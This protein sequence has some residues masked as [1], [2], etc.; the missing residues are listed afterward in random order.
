MKFVTENSAIAGTSCVSS[1]TSLRLSMPKCEKNT[2]LMNKVNAVMENIGFEPL[3]EKVTFGGSDAADLTAFGVPVLDQLGV[4]C[5][6][7][8]TINERIDLNSLPYCAKR[9]AAIAAL[10]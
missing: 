3:K 6:G 10:I 4:L 5:E 2:E 7:A 9:I 8:H 1:R